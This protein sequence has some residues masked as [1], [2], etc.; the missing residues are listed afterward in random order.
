MLRRKPL[1][2]LTIVG[3]TGGNPLCLSIQHS[4][5]Q[6]VLITPLVALI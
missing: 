3:A 4:N 2:L 5:F 1:F 6:G